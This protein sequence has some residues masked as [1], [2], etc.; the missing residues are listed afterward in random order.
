[1]NY[2]EGRIFARGKKGT[3][4][5]AWFADQRE[6]RMSTRSTDRR[7]AERKLREKL[8][9]KDKGEVHIPGAHRVTVGDLARML[10]E[11]HESRG[12]K[13]RVRI[14]QCM[15]HVLDHFGE[16]RR[17]ARITYAS[18][19]AYVGT[20]RAEGAE[21]AT[22]RFEL[23]VFSQSFK[24]ARKVGVLSSSPLFPTV[25]VRNVRTVHFTEEELGKLMAELPNYLA[26]VVRFAAATG[27]RL[28]EVL[29]LRW[30]AV[31][32]AAGTIRLE[33]GET[34]S[35]KGR[36]FPFKQFPS[37]A[38]VLEEQRQARWTVEREKG[39]DVTHVFHRRG[40]GLRDID[41]AWRAACER[42]KLDDRRFHDLRRY[43]AMRLVRAGVA[44]SEAMGLLGHETESMFV[45]YALNDVP[46]LERAVE[47]LAAL[48]SNH[49]E[50]SVPSARLGQ[51]LGQKRNPRP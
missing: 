47:K 18:L 50:P 10:R 3:L 51:K 48:D 39:I 5:I 15:R 1:V 26:P 34:K 38:A 12:T 35:G 30:T 6:L 33:P 21:P 27:W 31:D 44:R 7:V 17:A 13:S 42:A 37:L 19:E 2:G 9:A 14:G 41:E 36:V 43:A 23:A 4:W 16:H 8:A 28:M 32:F 46:A 25:R 29:S 20:R 45:R 11:H 49:A 40:K 24:V 22:I